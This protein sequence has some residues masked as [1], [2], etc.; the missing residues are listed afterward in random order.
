KTILAQTTADV[1]GPDGQPAT[2]TSTTYLQYPNHVRV[3][4]ALPGAD[5]QQIFDGEHAWI[6]DPRGVHTVDLLQ[7]R[8][9][10]ANLK[11][12]TLALLLGAQSG[13]IRLR[14]LPDVKD[15][16]GQLYHA[17]EFAAPTLEPLVMY[18]DTASALI[19]KQTYVSGA[20]GQPLI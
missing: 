16:S 8:M 4:T 1:T 20:P 6:K 14:I 15:D 11:R 9:L 13:T 18:I 19:R 5:V 17:L 12:D 3:E 2:V 10:E 7:V